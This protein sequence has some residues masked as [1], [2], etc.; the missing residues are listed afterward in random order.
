MLITDDYRAQNAA[1]HAE[2]PHYG[3]GGYLAAER[4]ERLA[5]KFNAGTILDYGCGKATLASALPHLAVSCYD[6]AVPGRDSPPSPADIVVCSDVMEHVEPDCLADVIRHLHSLSREVLYLEIATVP[7]L[8]YLPDG[9]N[10]HLIV[11]PAA[12]WL[13]KFAPLFEQLVVAAGDKDFAVLLKPRVA[14]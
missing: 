12:W 11:E 13:E 6:P 3:R 5:K 10:A 9:R 8:K 1:M 7:A 14:Q 4:V 2:K